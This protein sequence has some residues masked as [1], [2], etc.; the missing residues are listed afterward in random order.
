MNSTKTHGILDTRD[1]TIYEV[2]I[3]QYT[4]EGT[5]DA[6]LPHLDRL[7][8][9]GVGMLWFMPI[10]PISVTNRKGT[11]GSYYAI[12]DFDGVNPEFGDEA[13]FK[14]V[15]AA[16]HERG[17]K[18]IIDWVPNHSGCD[19]PWTVAHPERYQ[20]RPEE[21]AEGLFAYG[22]DDWTDTYRLDYTNPETADAMLASMMRWIREFDLDGFRCD[23]AAMVIREFWER[24]IPALRAE[25]DI[26]MLAEAE[27]KWMHDVGF[28]A[29][30]AWPLGHTVLAVAEGKK[31]PEAIRAQVL[32]DETIV[33]TGHRMHFTTNHDWNTWEG[34]AIDRLGGAHDAA[35]VLSFTLP[36][37]P[38][39][40][41]GQES[42]LDQAIEFFEKDPITWREHEHGEL[43]L[44]LAHLKR[45]EPALHH[46]PEGGSMHMID[47]GDEHVIAFERVKGESRVTVLAN[48]SANPVSVHV[49]TGDAVLIDEH[50]DRVS[51][52]R[53]LGP[54]QWA[55]L[56]HAG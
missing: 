1:T 18:A 31:K 42:G 6:F 48:M 49:E 5:F 50:G 44:T 54:W 21:Q 26:F 37:M 13:S 33:G 23:V 36:G 20:V 35:V 9:L 11:L 55:V 40:Y 45:A 7:A 22:A 30:Y 12:A 34:V 4:P 19:H 39:I 10:H 14:R 15:I 3:R 52:P 27:E 41:S 51:A 56:R 38:L 8:D 2:N 16:A 43:F 47:V 46:G 25:K 29:T 24:A 32:E 28:D 53:S 17:M